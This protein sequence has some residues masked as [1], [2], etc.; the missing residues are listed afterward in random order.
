MAAEPFRMLGNRG[1]A[2]L[3]A[4]STGC[5]RENGVRRVPDPAHLAYWIRR[6]GPHTPLPDSRTQ[7][8]R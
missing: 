3:P 4:D 2:A 8:A 5:I 1:D 6:A 7:R